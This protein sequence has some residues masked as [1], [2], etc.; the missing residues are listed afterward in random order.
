MELTGR[1]QKIL[2]AIVEQYIKT[3]EP[4]GSK[5]LQQ[6]LDL[7]LSSATIRNE[8]SELV[9]MG[10]LEQPHTSAGRVPSNQG[11]RY[12]VDHLMRRQDVDENFR[13]LL[14]VGIADGADDPEQLLE[15]A[16][17]VLAELTQCAA[18]STTPLGENATVRRIEL[19]P[20]SQ[21]M[22]MLLLLTSTGVLK[23]RMCRLDAPLTSVRMEV[24]YNTVEASLLGKNIADINTAM[25]QGITASLGEHALSLL[26]IMGVIAELA[27]SA[28]QNQL[29]VEG[30]S[31][32]LARKE[33]AGNINELMDFLQRGGPL[34]RLI[35]LNKADLDVRIGTENEYHQLETSSLILAKYSIDGDEVGTI[36]L[37]GPTRI[38]YAQ[39]IPS[40]QYLT[41]FVSDL[42][43]QALEE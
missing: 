26:P 4:V 18:V 14:E 6:S 7:A 39:L 19:V 13:K 12:Y 40:V 21:R 24:F 28:S 43:T 42:M 10:Y 1:K 8:M 31:N 32:L 34:K 5:M 25:L 22:A 2:A 38:N 41:Q 30:H 27:Q 11:Y 29:K 3:G 35:Q 17:G 37:I 9:A 33:Y 16:V 15:S 20:M 36:G 23:S